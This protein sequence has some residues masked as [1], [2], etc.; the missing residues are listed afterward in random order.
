MGLNLEF[1]RYDSCFSSEVSKL[2]LAHYLDLNGHFTTIYGHFFANYIDIFDKTENQAV[3]LRYVVCLNLKW[4]NLS[5][6]GKIGSGKN[7]KY[8]F[9]YWA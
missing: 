1:S 5:Q 6:T 4:R 2:P 7:A 3:I 8:F 9:S